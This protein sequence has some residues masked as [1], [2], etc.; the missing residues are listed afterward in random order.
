MC[1]AA[2]EKSDELTVVTQQLDSTLL[3][4]RNF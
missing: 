1:R 4:L 3:E 2:K